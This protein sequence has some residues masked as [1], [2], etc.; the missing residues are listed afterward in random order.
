MTAADGAFDS[1]VETAVATVTAG[2]A[3]RHF[4][5]VQAGDAASHSGTPNAA[6]Y[7]VADASQIGT[8][9]GTVTDHVSG[10]NL[11]AGSTLTRNFSLLADCVFFDDD[12]ENGSA[13]WTAQSP[14][15]IV[16]NVPG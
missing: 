15:A 14:W 7:D 5:Y 6:F 8:I 10:I 9:S 3:G 2:A 13:L 1:P 16:S 12:V 4:V 11:A